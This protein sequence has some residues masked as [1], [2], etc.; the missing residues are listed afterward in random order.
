[1]RKRVYSLGENSA[2][3]VDSVKVT[4]IF[5]VPCWCLVKCCLVQKLLSYLRVTQEKNSTDKAKKREAK[6]HQR[7]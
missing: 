4:V 6:T 7:G 5:S 3:F 2:E 1:M